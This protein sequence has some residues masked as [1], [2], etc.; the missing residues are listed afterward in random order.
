MSGQTE[1][2]LQH[3]LILTKNAPPKESCHRFC[4]IYF[5]VCFALGHLVLFNTELCSFDQLKSKTS[6]VFEGI[7]LWGAMSHYR[8][9]SSAWIWKVGGWNLHTRKSPD[10]YAVSRLQ[11]ELFLTPNGVKWHFAIFVLLKIW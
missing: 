3:T 8:H 7:G 2:T 4:S 9:Q 5:A 10:R 11:N 6:S 1:W